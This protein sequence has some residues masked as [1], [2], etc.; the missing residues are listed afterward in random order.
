MALYF[1]AGLIFVLAYVTIIRQLRVKPWLQAVL[2]VIFFLM[3]AKNP[4]LVLFGGNLLAPDLPGPVIVAASAAQFFLV[5]S[6][7]FS[8]CI[9][10][11]TTIVKFCTGK[12]V[13]LKIKRIILVSVM[14]LSL[15]IAA[16]GTYNAGLPPVNVFYS[17]SSPKYPEHFRI[18]QLS[19]THIGPNVS[20]E[21]IR[22]IIDRVNTLKPDVVLLTGDIIDVK[23]EPIKLQLDEF[24]KITAP[25][26]VY[27]VNGNHEYYSQTSSWENVWQRINIKMLHNA[28]EKLV[29]EHGVPFLVIAGVTDTQAQRCEPPEESPDFYK[30]MENIDKKLPVIMMSHRPDLFELSAGAGADITLSGHTHGG[31]LPVLRT[32]VSLFNKGY[33]SGLYENGD[34]KLIVSNGTILWAGFFVRLGVPAQIVVVDLKKE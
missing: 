12:H 16:L 2:A 13:H 19:D 30:A 15:G 3:A 17:F 23:Y 11:V 33:V 9:L 20:V 1:L 18:V 32:V 21:K 4:L 27:A 24:K 7:F 25:Y 8:I 22:D 34:K 14:I 28:N 10:T 31:M 26:G 5:T 29:N 6:I